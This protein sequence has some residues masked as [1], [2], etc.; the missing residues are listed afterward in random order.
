MTSTVI[1][2]AQA[3]G[4][5]G[6]NPLFQFAPFIIIGI[7]FYM[8][9]IRPERRKRADLERMLGNLK[10]NDRVI[11]IGGIY[12]TIVNAPQGSKEVTIKVDESSNTRLRVL[13][14]SISQ[15]LTPDE[16]GETLDA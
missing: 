3:N 1:L 6:V 4:N 7:L 2:V 5:N 8:M 9:L 11:T 12:G 15:V 16:S 10:K 13:R 14:S